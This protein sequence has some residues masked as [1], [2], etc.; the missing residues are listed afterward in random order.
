MQQH[1]K[2]SLRYVFFRLY[3]ND[4]LLDFLKEQLKNGLVLDHC[5]GNFFFFRRWQ[6]QNARLC[7]ISIP[8]SKPRVEDDD[9]VQ[10]YLD[11]AK[12]KGWQLLCVGDYESLLP[13][14]RRLYFYTCDDRAQ[15]LEQDEAADF[16]NAYRA[17]H[18]SLRS[19]VAWVLLA[20]LGLVATVPFMLADGLNFAMPV[21]D[22]A[23]LVSACAAMTLHLN[24]R[25]LYRRVTKKTPL[26]EDLGLRPAPAPENLRLWSMGASL[27][28]WC[29]CF[30]PD[31]WQK[32][33]GEIKTVSP[34]FFYS[35]LRKSKA[36]IRRTLFRLLRWKAAN[37]K[38]P[39][40]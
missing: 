5:K 29:C 3:S 7:V 4:E 35:A 28:V 40:I 17:Y 18:A 11:I 25:T 21:L 20:A 9:E 38:A 12:R 8:C 24:R 33:A 15:P 13:M 2:T 27:R 31:T 32:N 10:E 19:S 37:T 39:R 26:P 6:L 1:E 23:L 14:R 16:Q 34:A 30:F 22:A 36:H